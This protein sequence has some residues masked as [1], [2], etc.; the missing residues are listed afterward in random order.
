MI[1]KRCSNFACWWTGCVVAAALASGGCHESD[2]GST[3]ATSTSSNVAALASEP[4]DEAATG[5]DSGEDASRILLAQATSPLLAA[6]PPPE[7]LLK[8]WPKPSVAFVLSGEQRGYLEP[9]GCSERQS[10]GLARRAD[11]VQQLQARGWTVTGFDLGGTLKRTRRQ[12]EMKLEV[13]RDSLNAMGYRGLGLGAED[14]KLGVLKLFESFARTQNDETFDLPFLSAN[15]T[16]LTTREIGTPLEY[17]VVQSGGVKIAVTSVLGQTFQKEM[18]PPGAEPDPNE[19]RIDPIDQVLP[20]VIERMRAERPDVMLLLSYARRPESA[21]IAERYPVFDLVVTAGSPEDPVGRIER[22]GDSLFLKV[23]TKG[24]NVGVV[25]YYPN[26][27]PKFRF[28]VV[29]LDRFR[30]G[31]APVVDRRMAVYQQLLRETNLIAN[32]PSIRHSFGDDYRFL[33]S[34]KCAECHDEAYEI[35]KDTPHAHAYDSLTVA[36]A[37]QHQ[38]PGMAARVRVDRIHDPECV[39]CHTAGWDPQDVLRFEGGFTGIETTPHLVGVNC[40]NC[41][42]PASKH[43]AAEESGADEAVIAAERLKLHLT[44]E[45]A[46][47]GLCSQCHDFENSPDFDFDVYWPKVDH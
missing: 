2:D 15:V 44:V 35:W 20:G 43:V 30:F 41:H 6:E 38:D 14:L 25:G 11:L 23:G 13:T 37:R 12:S 5:A 24:K 19:I 21:Q 36:W 26:S 7:P 32:E 28:E 9:C 3:L 17:R 46:R 29:E 22:V 27:V 4:A 18:F 8:S 34:Q 10:G 42:G 39:N 40:E 1:P 33:G 47:S 45:S 16:F 31:H